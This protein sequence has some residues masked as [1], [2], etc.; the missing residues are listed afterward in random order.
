MNNIEAKIK[1]LG[2]SVGVALYDK[3]W[4]VLIDNHWLETE[5]FLKL[6]DAYNWIAKK[7][8]LDNLVSKDEVIKYLNKNAKEFVG[9]NFDTGDYI[10]VADL[11]KWLEDK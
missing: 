6:D 4:Y 11:E 10:N 3:K 5:G 7:F 1:E 2:L 9:Y 8:N